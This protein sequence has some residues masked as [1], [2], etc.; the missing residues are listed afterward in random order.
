MNSRIPPSERTGFTIIE[1]LVA[2]ALSSLLMAAL[3]SS[4]SVYWSTANESYEEIERYQIARALLRQ[5][6]RDIKSCT[7]VEQEIMDSDSDSDTTTDTDTD[8]V[9]T[10]NAMAS[11]TTGLFGTD[12]DLVLYISRPDK[13]MGYVSAQELLAPS[14]RSSESM[15]IR[16]FLAETGVGGLSSLMA[17]DALA[18]QSSSD[19]VAGL[20]VMKGDLI[21]LSTAINQG[22]IEMQRDASTM[23]AREVAMIQ[24]LYFDG[25]DELPEWDSTIQNAMPQAVIIELTLRTLL[26][27]SETRNPEEIPGYL[28]ETLHRL[29]VPIPVAVPYVGED[30]L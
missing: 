18:G 4:M 24:F 2:L 15:I 17:E 16:Y 21:G 12:R 11:Y 28:P 19:N 7:F 27:E 26:A 23:L 25:V 6:A 29:V 20:A 10:E 30:G 14:D 8:A 5:M 9:D 1:V 22:D 3:Y 13:G